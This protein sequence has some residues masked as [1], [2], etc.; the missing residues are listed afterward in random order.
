MANYLLLLTAANAYAVD[1]PRWQPHDFSFAST[2][3]LAKPFA[4]DFS[5]AVTGPSHRTF[6]T[7]GFYD[8]GGTWKVRV[9]PDAEGAWSLITHSSAPGLD[10][11]AAHFTCVANTNPE[12]HGLVTPLQAEWYQPLT[13]KRV[14]ADALANGSAQ[15]T[16]P[17]S[18]GSG[19]VA[20]HVGIRSPRSLVD[21]AS[22]PTQKRNVTV[23]YDH[24]LPQLEF[25]AQEIERASNTPA[26]IQ[27]ILDV[28]PSATAAPQS[29]TIRKTPEGVVVAGADA[30]G[31]MY[32]G[33]D[34]AEAIRLETL[35]S[36]KDGEHKPFIARRGIK[37]NIPL[38]ARTPSYS[39]A[40]DA[41]QQN[42]PEMWSVEFWHTFLDEM[43]RDRF[44]VLT[45]WN[46]HPFP[47]MVKVPEYPDVALDDVMRTTVK[48]DS[49][50]SLSGKDMVRPEMLAHLETVKKMTIA[51]KIEFWRAVMAYAHD[52]GIE[53]Y[54][55]TWNIFAW[56]ADGKYG[57]TTAQDNKTTI[58]YM[59]KSVRELFLTYPLLAGIG[60]TAGENMQN[61]KGEFSNEKWLWQTYGEGI[62][63]VKKLQPN[64]SIRLIHRFHETSFPSI[65]AEWRDYPDTFDFSYKYSV[66]HM[67]SS[68]S[69]PFG[70][71][72]F[73]ELPSNLRTW[74]TVR[75]DDIYNFRWG[76]PAYAREYVRNMPGPDKIAGYYT[77]CDGT[78]WGRE[79]I[80]TEPEKPRQ[81]I[82][83]KQ[84]YSFMLWGRLSCDPTLPDALFEQ[85]LAQR[86]PEAPAAKLFAAS[87]AASKI[88]P[89]ITR[90]F[91]GDI[92]LKWFPEACI[93]HP[94]RFYTVTDFI[95]GDTMP[96]SGIINIRDYRDR[97]KDGMTPVQVAEALKG[98]AQT[99]LQI[100]R[101]MPAAPSKE[102]RLTLGD[103]TAMAH[104]GSYYAEKILGATDLALFEKTG[105]PEEQASAVRHLEA[106]L[107]HW[108]EYA[109]VA[110]SQYQPQLLTRIGYVDLNALTASVQNDVSIARE[111]KP[112]P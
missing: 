66:A 95:N 60:I 27:V 10:G 49:T 112:K 42:I 111:W 58:D 65:M 43:A 48:F 41:A 101:E 6:T 28:T 3:N 100:L 21:R 36:L 8:G 75:N 69:P 83:Q 79:F 89:Q 16:P 110:S 54:L 90:F 70:K 85:T 56:G 4:L 87:S 12:V 94:A 7:P 63:D 24:H 35:A 96:G 15:L 45:L 34:V 108:K 51:E 81:L 14:A 107:Q 25:A 106:A 97:T 2:A 61:L 23:V 71:Q 102:L 53:V 31:A 30:V 103:L 59:R 78:I 19:P 5:V 92:D 109:T 84:W 80:S 82:I 88:I 74:L 40:G 1:V 86:F 62:C 55:F 39:D 91:W 20:L 98:D 52:R 68:T 76:D 26:P 105:E 38:D 11:L 99:T 9:A 104:L 17:E 50:F 22:A 93:H 37:F 33:L 67:Y 77:G 46:L 73:A 72:T 57:I 29:Y 47:S 13:G 44:N 64:R 32:G 18:F